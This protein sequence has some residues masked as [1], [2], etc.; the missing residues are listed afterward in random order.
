MTLR[1]EDGHLHARALRD[2]ILCGGDG[3]VNRFVDDMI[4]ADI[5]KV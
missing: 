4:G 1:G 5:S 2:F 3:T